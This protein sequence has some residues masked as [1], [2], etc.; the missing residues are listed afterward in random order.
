MYMR[1]CVCVWCVCVRV[2]MP[3]CVRV[4]VRARARARVRVC[5]RACVCVSV[6]R[7]TDR[8]QPRVLVIAP[9]ASRVAVGSD[10][11]GAGR[12]PLGSRLPSAPGAHNQRDR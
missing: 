10:N 8:L 6:C 1:E 9:Q 3:E 11:H 2:Y 7:L 5:V 4:R 12:D